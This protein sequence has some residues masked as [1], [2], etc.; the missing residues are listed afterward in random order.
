VGNV[1][2]RFIIASRT[3]SSE[4]RKKTLELMKRENKNI[5]KTD[6]WRQLVK[7][8]VDIVFELIMEGWS[9]GHPVEL[10]PHP[11]SAY[12]RL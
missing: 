6:N 9:Y 11:Q 5:M 2:E 1:L 7:D 12:D 8:N 10:L 3:D 4:L